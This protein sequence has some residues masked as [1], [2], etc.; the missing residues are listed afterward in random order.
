[1]FK[2]RRPVRQKHPFPAK[3]ERPSRAVAARVL[4]DLYTPTVDSV[5]VLRRPRRAALPIEQDVR[6]HERR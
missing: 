4:A 1:M 3:P 2:K 6:L 5:D